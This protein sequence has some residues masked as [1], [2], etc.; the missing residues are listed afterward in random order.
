MTIN[1]KKTTLLSIAFA[2]LLSI[3]FAFISPVAKAEYYPSISENGKY[4]YNVSNPTGEL[5]INALETYDAYSVS[6]QFTYYKKQR[7]GKYKKVHVTS[8]KKSKD[9]KVSN[10]VKVSAGTYKV[11]LNTTYKKTKNGKT[12]KESTFLQDSDFMDII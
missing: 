7:S 5:K 8:S 10:N 2:L 12:Y 11:K 3:A 6:T 4:Q 1:L 9:G